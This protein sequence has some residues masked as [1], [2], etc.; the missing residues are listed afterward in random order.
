MNHRSPGAA[1]VC[2]C[3]VFFTAPVTRAQEVGP[4]SVRVD[5]GAPPTSTRAELDAQRLVV[6]GKATGAIGLGVLGLGGFLLVGG[7]ASSGVGFEDEGE[8]GKRLA[9]AGFGLALVGALVAVGGVAAYL[10]GHRRLDRLRRARVTAGWVPGGAAVQVG[11]R[12]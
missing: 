6:R 5:V 12:F 9:A 4:V 10:A 7:L 11:V 8:T 1:V 3:A 2:A